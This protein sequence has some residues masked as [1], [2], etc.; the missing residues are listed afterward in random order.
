M[1]QREK[2]I[3]LLNGWAKENNDGIH[4]DSVAD[5]LL[6]NGVVVLPC[7]VGDTVYVISKCK[8]IRMYY[9][10][11]YF[12]GTGASECPFENV[13]EYEDC[14][15]ENVRIFETTVTGFTYEN[16]EYPLSFHTFLEGLNVEDDCW[17]KTVFLTREE[18]EAALER[19]NNSN[20]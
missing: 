15:D 18:A 8:D 20:G 19:M 17:G 12:D 6:A 14:S 9:D 3:E 13:C 5:Y 7:K 11:D 4:A 10:N 2:L 1:N 16:H